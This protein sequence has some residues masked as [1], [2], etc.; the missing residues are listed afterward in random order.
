MNDEMKQEI[1]FDVIMKAQRND[2]VLVQMEPF[3]IE[4]Y[5]DFWSDDKTPFDAHLFTSFPCK[6]EWIQSGTMTT[7]LYEKS[8][9]TRVVHHGENLGDG[10]YGRGIIN[11]IRDK[12]LHCRMEP[13]DNYVIP[14][15]FEHPALA[16]RGRENSL[17]HPGCRIVTFVYWTKYEGGS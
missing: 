14:G 8:G 11:C 1:I 9:V 15:C 7:R 13:V 3:D 6:N 2:A 5:K 12:S 17:C 10:R 16:E 4:V